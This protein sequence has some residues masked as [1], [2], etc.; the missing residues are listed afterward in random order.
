MRNTQLWISALTLGSF[1]GLL[2]LAYYLIF[3]GAGFFNIAIGAY[4]SMGGL[5]TSW[6]VIKKDLSLWP[7]VAIALIGVMALAGL[8]EVAVVRVVQ[9]RGRGTELAALVSVTAVLF[10][11]SQFAG[12][13]FG[14]TTLPGQQL[15]KIDP[16]EIGDA[17]ITANTLI[18]ILFTFAIFLILAVLIRTTRAGRLLRAVGDSNP[19]AALLGLPVR[20]VRLGA[21]F[22]AGLLAGIAGL[23]F[24]SQ[25]GVSSTQRLELGDPRVPRR[26]HRRVRERVR[27]PRR[28]PGAGGDADLRPVL[29]RRQRVE[30]RAPGG[31][32]G[33]LRP[34]TARSLLPAG[35]RMSVDVV[36]RR[37]VESARRRGL[38]DKGSLVTAAVIGLLLILWAGDNSYRYS[39]VQTAAAYALIGVGVYIPF[40]MGGSLSLAYAAYA[41]I[42]GY[43][44]ALIADKTSLP[45]LIGWLIGPLAAGFAAVVLGQLTRR[46]SGLYLAAITYLFAQAFQS[47]LN[48]APG[49]TGGEAGIGNLRRTSVFGWIPGDRGESCSPSCSAP[50]GFVVDR[51][52]LSR[53]ASRCGR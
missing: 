52:R 14:Y 37:R 50:V 45:V 1:Y 35:S 36:D 32:G 18:M 47:W 19:V 2:G 3:I 24:S 48:S 38:H 51:L 23:L 30:H 15:L 5:I 26:R 40:I 28:R 21:F 29:L 12:F 10:L 33:L 17:V 6:L 20:R 25:A 31:R 13:T 46:F 53:G 22:I 42:G 27:A 34:A 4:A 11:I 44:V 8:T 41:S 49:I 7:A 9:R 16:I 43:S 39:L